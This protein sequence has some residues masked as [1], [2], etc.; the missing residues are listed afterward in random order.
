[1]LD[2]ILRYEVWL[3]AAL[4]LVAADVLLG[5]D[6][7]LRPLALARRLPV[8]RCCCRTPCRYPIPVTGRPC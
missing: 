1:M 2:L 5:L 6:F 3:I 7:I 4:V 8:C